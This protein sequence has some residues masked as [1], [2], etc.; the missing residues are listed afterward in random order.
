MTTD[1]FVTFKI[2]QNCTRYNNCNPQSRRKVKIKTFG[3]LLNLLPSVSNSFFKGLA[4]SLEF[5]DRVIYEHLIAEST[6]GKRCG[7]YCLLQPEATWFNAFFV[8][9]FCWQS[10]V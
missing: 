2:L 8:V 3:N 4:N 5:C 6:K 1:S 10:P 7:W 9:W